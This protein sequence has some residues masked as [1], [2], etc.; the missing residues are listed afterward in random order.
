MLTIAP[1]EMLRVA[2]SD[3]WCKPD[4]SEIEMVIVWFSD[5]GASRKKPSTRELPTKASKDRNREQP[6]HVARISAPD[7]LERYGTKIAEWGDGTASRGIS[8]Q[9]SFR[10]QRHQL[11]LLMQDDPAQRVELADPWRA[12]QH[13]FGMRIAGV[14]AL[15][16][17]SRTEVDVLGVCLSI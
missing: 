3:R 2:S 7:Q 12:L 14:P 5:A 6:C 9:D 17:A 10:C 1:D 16:D 8:Q 11:H 13:G 15:Y 4:E